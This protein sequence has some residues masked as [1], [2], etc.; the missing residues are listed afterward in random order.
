VVRYLLAE[1][2]TDRWEVWPLPTSEGLGIPVFSD[3]AKV[4]AF[5][6]ANWESLGPGSEPIGLHE[7]QLA[8][9]LEKQANEEGIE[10]V[11][12]DPPPMPATALWTANQTVDVG[13]IRA[14]VRALR[15]P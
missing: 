5:I 14:Y 11:V 3:E 8:D 4:Q 12:L 6:E 2:Y 1:R 9:F 15:R 10:C 7:H 13:S